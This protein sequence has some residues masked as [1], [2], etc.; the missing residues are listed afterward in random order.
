MKRKSV[1]PVYSMCVFSGTVC[2]AASAGVCLLSRFRD[3]QRTADDAGEI[4]GA[5]IPGHGAADRPRFSGSGGGPGRIP[6]GIFPAGTACAFGTVHAL[7]AL[8]AGCRTDHCF[9]CLFI[10]YIRKVYFLFGCTTTSST[11]ISCF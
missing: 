4:S 2:P 11:F 10:S 9:Q 3:Q 7:D 5:S 6:R 8:S 1:K